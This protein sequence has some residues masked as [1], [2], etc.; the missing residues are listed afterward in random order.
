LPRSASVRLRSRPI[1]SLA[2]SLSAA[3]KENKYVV[4]L[5]FSL[6]PVFVTFYS[7]VYD[8]SS[9]FFSAFLIPPS[10][11]LIHSTL[12]HSLSLSLSLVLRHL[13]FCSSALL[14]HSRLR[15]VFHSRFSFLQYYF[16]VSVFTLSFSRSLYSLE[17][18]FLFF[19][20]CFLSTSQQSTRIAR[21]IRK[22]VTRFTLV[23]AFRR[24]GS[25][26]KKRTYDDRT[27]LST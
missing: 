20:F 17:F 4:P 12:S 26:R 6:S 2:R 14:F 22:N 25:R 8:L 24:K 10:L 1:L 5:F 13:S 9:F 18:F 27:M 7:D 16:S 21:V 15:V 11:S 19:A 23:N 3:R